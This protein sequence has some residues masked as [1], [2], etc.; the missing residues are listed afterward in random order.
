MVISMLISSNMKNF[1][2]VWKNIEVHMRNFAHAA[3]KWVSVRMCD[4][5]G[6]FQFLYLQTDLQSPAACSEP[7]I[8]YNSCN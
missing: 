3:K 8:K 5:Y 6:Y 4:L 7:L 1:S 2:T